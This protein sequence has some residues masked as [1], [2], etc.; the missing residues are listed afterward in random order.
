MNGDAKEKQGAEPFKKMI[1]VLRA[2]V[3]ICS[4]L[5]FRL[6]KKPFGREFSIM[7]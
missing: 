1:P 5:I 2:V 6:F 7:M 4:I 3:L